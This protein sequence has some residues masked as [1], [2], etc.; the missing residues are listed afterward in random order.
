MSETLSTLS[1][2]SFAIAGV[3]L[4]IAIILWFYF[5]IPTV[6][7]DL[8]GRTAKK[9]IEKMRIANERTGTKNYKESKTNAERG[10]LTGT[11]PDMGKTSNKKEPADEEMPETALLDEN[12]ETN[13]ES[14]ETGVLY[15]EST[16]LLDGMEKTSL[17][18]DENATARLDVLLEKEKNKTGGKK[19]IMIEEIMLIHTNEEINLERKVDCKWPN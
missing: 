18:E 9:S 10:K 14:K 2:I 17:L 3:C 8:S 1:V 11:M 15:E 19:L 16:E 4:A 5:R 6:I 12:L 13:F 7:G